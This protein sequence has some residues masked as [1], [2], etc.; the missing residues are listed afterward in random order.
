MGKS[1]I[2]EGFQ[3]CLLAALIITG[4]VYAIKGYVIAPAILTIPITNLFVRITK[5]C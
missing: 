4:L 5:D 1:S 3:I 2:G